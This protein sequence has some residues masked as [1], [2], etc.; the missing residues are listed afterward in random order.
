MRNDG[1]DAVRI[2]QVQVNDAF[3]QFT[4]ADD[5]DRPARNRDGR[6]AQPWIEGEA[7]EVALLTSTRRRRSPTRSRPRSRRRPRDLS[8][9]GA[10]G[11]ARHLR[12]RDPDRARDAV[13]AVD[14]PHPAELA[15]GASWRSPSG[16]SAFLAID[17]T[18]EGLELAGEGSQAFGG[19]ALVLLG[20]AVAYLA[21]DAAC[22]RGSRSQRAGARAGRPAARSRCWSPSASACTT[23]ARAWPSAPPTPPARSRW[24][25]SSCRLRAAQHH[26]GPGDRRA[27][28]RTRSPSLGAA[29]RARRCSPGAPAVLGAW[30]GAAA[31]NAVARRVPVRLRRGRDRAGHRPA[32]AVAA[33]RRRPH[34]PSRRRRRP[35]GG[36]GDHVRH[37]PAG[38]RLMAA[39]GAPRPSEA[40]EDYAK[41]IYALQRRARRRAGGDQR[42][43]RAP[44]RHP[45]VGVGDGQE[46]RRARARRARAVPRRRA[47]RRP[48]SA[49]R[50]R[51]CA[52]TA[53]SSSTS[54][55]TSTC[56]GTASTRRP[57][58]SSTCISEDLEARI[59][60]KLGHPTHDPH[61]DPIPD[62]DLRIDEGDTRSLADLAAGRPRP[63]RA[64]VGLRPGDA[65]LPRRARRPRSATISRS[66]DRQ[67][68][69]GPL[70]VRFGDARHMLGGRWRRPCASRFVAEDRPRRM[71]AFDRLGRY[72]CRSEHHRRGDRL[73][74]GSVAARRRAGR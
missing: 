38:E 22:R 42:A 63:L 37:R 19:A 26:R 52:T 45:G 60:A 13:A 23:S 73:T 5:A 56:P 28:R 2:A 44:G 71:L 61:G 74:A 62:A 64:R 10:D 67:P 57:R 8:F 46:A 4:G 12:R 48:A 41:A 27:D 25:R 1:P 6:I 15:A 40:I 18:L 16:C 69:G 20:A 30:I 17:A 58:R 66:L 21:L 9:F 68:F 70:T 49:S 53:C 36:H 33:R 14:A 51:C 50:S 55:S 54:P 43:G 72:S 35:A 29:R 39:H 34:A 65:P 24:A 31:F 3:A 11:A 7:Y 47:D 32:R 59:A